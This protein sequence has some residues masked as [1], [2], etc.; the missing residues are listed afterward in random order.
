M[1]RLLLILVIV[2]LAVLLWRGLQKK[3]KTQDNKNGPKALDMIRCDYCGLHVPKNSALLRQGRR[4]C[5]EEHM[6]IDNNR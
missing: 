3:I 5:S 2:L 6:R 4:Y 1:A